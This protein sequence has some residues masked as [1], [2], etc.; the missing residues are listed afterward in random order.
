M[1]DKVS[2]LLA[3]MAGIFLLWPVMG[4]ATAEEKAM[5]RTVTVSASGQVSAEP[6]QARITTGVVSEAAT[7]SEA[8]AKNTDAMKKVIAELKG[9]GIEAKDI[10]TSSFNVEPVV[11]YTKVCAPVR[12]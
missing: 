8:L 1:T 3:L 12:K 2:N 6:D 7:A 9:K 5:E 11:V 4:H 10:Q